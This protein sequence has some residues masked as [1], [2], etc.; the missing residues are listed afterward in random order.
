MK[1]TILAIALAGCWHDSPAKDDT[2]PGPQLGESR[3]SPGADPTRPAPITADDPEVMNMSAGISPAQLGRATSAPPPA[4]PVREPTTS[5]PVQQPT[6]IAPPTTEP[7]PVE[8]QNPAPPPPPE[9][10][11][12]TPAPTPAPAAQA[13]AASVATPP[14]Q[15]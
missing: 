7:A 11:A 9:S 14:P 2:F 1:I 12:P 8:P 6:E 3:A 10:Q 4:A 13:P 5:T 15:P